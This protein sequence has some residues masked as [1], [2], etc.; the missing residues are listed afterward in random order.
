MKPITVHVLVLYGIEINNMQKKPI[1][2]LI[3]EDDALS[4]EALSSFLSKNGFCVVGI[5]DNAIEAEQC[6]I[7]TMTDVLLVDIGLKGGKDGIMLVE[8]L[9]N[10][11]QVPVVY[12]SGMED[13]EIIRRMKDT[14]PVAFL[15]KPYSML[16]VAVS[17]ELSVER[18]IGLMDRTAQRNMVKVQI[19]NDEEK[20]REKEKFLVLDD[21]LIFKYNY[22]YI[23]LHVKHVLY[24][25]A[26]KNFV[27]IVTGSKKYILRL[28]IQ[29][30]ASAMAMFG[31]VRIHRSYII[32][33][34]SID[35]FSC[36]EVIVGATHLP[37][38]RNY[39]CK[40]EESLRLRKAMV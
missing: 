16:N 22:Q 24:I 10:I 21:F 2:V 18:G 27:H 7:S 32:N 38:G 15:S 36:S 11:R 39:R 3:I 9:M 29:Q 35:K 4:A 1:R 8:R 5:A 31:F 20:L 28:S 34:S 37:I 6:F 30:V 40:L 17:L 12:M 25:E 19:K 23:R 13:Y 26:D 33:V 14:R